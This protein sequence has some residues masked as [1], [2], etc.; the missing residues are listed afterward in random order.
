[1][2]FKLNWQ[3]VCLNGALIGIRKYQTVGLALKSN[4]PQKYKLADNWRRLPKGRC[5]VSVESGVF[6]RLRKAKSS[7]MPLT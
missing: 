7:P 5:V 6:A 2:P 1:M 4:L 3:A